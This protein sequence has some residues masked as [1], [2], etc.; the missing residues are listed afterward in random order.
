MPFGISGSWAQGGRIG[1]SG[2]GERQGL[3]SGSGSRILSHE[4]SMKYL[5]L[6]A[7]W[8][9]VNVCLYRHRPLPQ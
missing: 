9:H 5:R 2:G 3:L 8:K 6:R 1:G 7:S 4:A